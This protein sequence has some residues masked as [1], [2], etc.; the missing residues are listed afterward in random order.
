MGTGSL[1]AAVIGGI[2]GAVTAVGPGH[3]SIRRVPSLL[4]G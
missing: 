2:A 3:T 4:L 1:K